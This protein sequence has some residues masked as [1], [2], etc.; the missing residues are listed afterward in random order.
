MMWMINDAHMIRGDECGQNFP[1]FVSQLRKTAGKR[2]PGNYP[3]RKYSKHTPEEQLQRYIW[4][5]AVVM[6]FNETK[7][8]SFLHLTF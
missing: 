5:T 1:T 3:D 2:Q 4:V 6:S 8:F 7:L